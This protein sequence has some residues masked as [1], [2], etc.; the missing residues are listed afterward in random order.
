MQNQ[1]M[2]GKPPSL[3][4]PVE[5]GFTGLI[6]PENTHQNEDMNIED[7]NDDNDVLFVSTTSNEKS[8]KSRGDRCHERGKYFSKWFQPY[9]F[10]LTA[11]S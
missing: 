5:A 1:K 2:M 3:P 9:V 4:P 6:V 10:L 11:V 8:H 7:D